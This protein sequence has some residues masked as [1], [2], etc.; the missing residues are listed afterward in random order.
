MP[1]DAP[2][3]HAL[4]RETGSTLLLLAAPSHTGK[5]HSVTSRA[6]RRDGSLKTADMKK[7][8]R[9]FTEIASRQ[10]IM[11][12]SLLEQL[13]RACLSSHDGAPLSCGGAR[14]EDLRALDTA[15]SGLRALRALYGRREMHWTEEKLKLDE[16]KEKV[17]LLLKQVLGVG[18][19][20]TIGDLTCPTLLT[21]LFLFIFGLFMTSYVA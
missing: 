3:F 16:D 10:C 20:G 12:P 14:E 21:L 7:I 2:Q 1:D 4:D 13:S 8:R 11:R 9:V 15:I 6:L 18:V 17:Q 19:F 5:F